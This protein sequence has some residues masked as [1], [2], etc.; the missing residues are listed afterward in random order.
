M[1]LPFESGDLPITEKDIRACCDA[2]RLPRTENEEIAIA[3][4]HRSNLVFGGLDWAMSSDES[5]SSY[6]KM[7]IFAYYNGK[8]KLIHAEQFSGT[9][10]TDP[11]LRLRRIVE[12]IERYNV[13]VLGCDY[14]MGYNENQRLKKV[15]PNRVI[16]FHYYGSSTGTVRTKYDPQGEKY[17]LP[18]TPSINEF[19]RDL[20]ARRFVFP[21]WSDER[22]KQHLQDYMRVT[23]EVNDKTRTIQFQKTGTDDF[24][25][26]SNYANMARRMYFGGEMV[27]DA[28]GKAAA[29]GWHDDGIYGL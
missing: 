6:T 11:D 13:T 14:G 16:T 5:T 4:E 29:S 18:K 23:R 7:G 26:V 20:K 12:L 10:G 28:P 22:A 1:G 24:L 2:Y 25:Q 21:E 17:A 27:E 9:I 15:Y 3:K 8:L 19:I